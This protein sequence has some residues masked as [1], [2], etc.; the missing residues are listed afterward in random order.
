[1]VAFG[2]WS[3]PEFNVKGDFMNGVNGSKT[4]Q[5]VVNASMNKPSPGSG[6]NPF[7]SMLTHSIQW[8]KPTQPLPPVQGQ[9]GSGVGVSSVQPGGWNGPDS[10]FV[11]INKGGSPVPPPTG[12][13]QPSMPGG[14]L[15]PAPVTG[16][17]TGI[18]PRVVDESGQRT[19]TGVDPRVGE[20][21]QRENAQDRTNTDRG[22]F[23]QVDPRMAE[24]QRISQIVRAR[25][26]ER[27][28][29]TGG[30]NGGIG[31]G[32]GNASGGAG[33]GGGS[34]GG[35]TSGGGT[36]VTAGP[37]GTPPTY[38]PFDPST[39]TFEDILTQIQQ[40]NAPAFQK[41]QQDLSS[42]MLHMA[43]VTG[44]SNS[45]GFGQTYGDQMGALVGQQQA[46]MSD[47]ALAAR[48]AALDRIMQTNQFENQFELE[49]WANANKFELEKYG[50]DKDVLAR[51]YA[52]DQGLKGARAAA[53]ATRAA[54][55][56]G[57]DASRYNAG[58]DF[59]SRL[60][61]Y[62]VTRENNLMNNMLGYASLGP[63]WAKLILGSSPENFLNGIGS[64]PGNI[65]VKP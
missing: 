7:E 16:P 4:S 26:G 44:A 37:A 19:Q 24:D 14:P 25:Q 57:A 45:G 11:P 49:K 53:G 61:G 5:S 38:K 55:A 29:G 22:G 48:E 39:A 32:G 9:M 54:A 3:P 6:S 59:Q 13:P 2:K 30:G 62:D 56:M 42:Q 35:G 12:F 47:Q 64:V 60:I 36:T 34:V 41:A 28:T 8:Q 33:G 65:F 51:K 20:V 46:K 1:M 18:D 17:P 15:K 40:L 21:N 27:R 50:I 63:E 43:G 58:L 31:G 10:G 23:T 52:A